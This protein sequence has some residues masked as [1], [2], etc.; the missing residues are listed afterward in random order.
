M[1]SVAIACFLA[2]PS[3]PAPLPKP[4]REPIAVSKGFAPGKYLVE[5]GRAQVVYD[6]RAD[7]TCT[8]YDEWGLPDRREDWVLEEWL[9]DCHALII[10][11]EGTKPAGVSN[12]H[13]AG[14]FN[15]KTLKG[16]NFLGGGEF[17]LAKLP[18]K[19]KSKPTPPERE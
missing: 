7:G 6:F 17:S 5:M 1:Y 11:P 12:A 14:T 15:P 16:R 4:G 19:R 3:A 13:W 10:Y 9:D 2:V 8:S 18:I